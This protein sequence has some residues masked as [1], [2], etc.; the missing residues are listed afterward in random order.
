MRL[1]AWNTNYNQRRHSLEAAVDLLQPL[2][3]DILVLSEV[4]PPCVGNPLGA[5]WIGDATPGLAVIAKPGFHLAPH[6]ANAGAPPLMGGFSI[7]GPVTFDLLAVWPVQQPSGA[8]YHKILM[9]GLERYAAMLTGPRAIMAG[10]L[11]SSSRVVAQ[12]QTHPKFVEAAQELGLRSVYHT[13][14][15]E[16]HG[17]ESIPTYDHASGKSRS[18]HLDYCFVAHALTASANLGILRGD[19]WRSRSDHS[20]LV[21]DI[22][23]AAL[24]P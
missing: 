20:P 11:N 14:F 17:E 19:E 1:V 7:S 13:Q 10:D 21:L 18:F 12:Q 3:A 16:S 15:G 9:A 4:A 6:I 8:S 22:P 23:D 24:A 5:H 2:H